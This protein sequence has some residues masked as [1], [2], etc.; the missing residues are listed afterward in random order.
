LR[1]ADWENILY[2]LATLSVMIAISMEA[3]N[4]GTDVV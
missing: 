2:C 1:R 3:S 4:I